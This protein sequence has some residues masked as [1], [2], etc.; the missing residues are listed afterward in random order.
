MQLRLR[1]LEGCLTVK[2]WVPQTLVIS[3]LTAQR[4]GTQVLD[5]VAVA[6]GMR[7]QVRRGVHSFAGGTMHECACSN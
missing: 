2:K 5:A 3:N 7:A 1:N 4:S 6:S